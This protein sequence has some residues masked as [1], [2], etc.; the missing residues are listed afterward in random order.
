MKSDS[1]RYPTDIQP[2]TITDPRFSQ[3]FTTAIIL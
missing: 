3:K 2:N 1:K